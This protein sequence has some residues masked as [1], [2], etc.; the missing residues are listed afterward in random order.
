MLSP[1]SRLQGAQ[2]VRVVDAE[3]EPK[4]RCRTRV[5]PRD[6]D[7][8]GEASKVAVATMVVV[9]AAVVVESRHEMHRT[10]R[11]RLDLMDGREPVPVQIKTH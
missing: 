8:P 5:P 3:G 2:G 1:L 7:E 9:Y 11:R 6:K 4:P 10:R